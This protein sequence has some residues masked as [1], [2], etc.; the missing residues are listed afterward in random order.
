M[1]SVLSYSFFFFFLWTLLLIHLS[2]HVVPDR[3][4]LVSGDKLKV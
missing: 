4:T 2:L 3:L 1:V